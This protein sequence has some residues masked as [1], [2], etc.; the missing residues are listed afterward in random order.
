VVYH[1]GRIYTMDETQ[2]WAEAVAIKDGKFMLVGSDA[3][4]LDIAN[5]ETQ[6]IDLKG[7]LVLPGL[8]DSN[9]QP[10]R[11]QLL[12]FE[13]H[14]PPAAPLADI[15]TAVA[16]YANAHP[17]APWI[18]G[19]TYNAAVFEN[20]PPNRYVLDDIVSDRPVYLEASDGDAVWVNSKAM[21]IAGV[22][23]TTRS[24]LGGVIERDDDGK[25][26]GV[27]RG[28]AVAMIKRHIP[29]FDCETHRS[30]AEDIVAELN[31]YGITGAKA[32]PGDQEALRALN[33]LDRE[34]TLRMRFAV[35]T[36]W[37]DPFSPQLE[38][39]R[40]LIL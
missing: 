3:A 10:L 13:L 24:P 6:L 36:P 2:P 15:L 30:A 11:G 29:H 34:G 27:F 40:Q 1:N 18:R 21:E 4:A 12:R 5:R 17:D 25:P 28:T 22:T 35:A 23:D 38:E 7:L 32:A 16:T 26:S 9:I 20:V 39:D 14:L 37:R 8:I 19:G 31:T 33:E